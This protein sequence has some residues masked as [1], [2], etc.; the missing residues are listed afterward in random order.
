VVPATLTL[1][2]YNAP[3]KWAAMLVQ[4]TIVTSFAKMWKLVRITADCGDIM[5]AWSCPTYCVNVACLRIASRKS[6]YF[7]GLPQPLEVWDLINWSVSKT[8]YRNV[9]TTHW[10][11]VV[12]SPWHNRHWFF[13][14]GRMTH[15]NISYFNKLRDPRC[16]TRMQKTDFCGSQYLS[17]NVM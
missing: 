13:L 7:A 6:Q 9:S 14:M 5:L 2:R 15:E 1:T 12:P 11:Y 8:Q 16:C 17:H 10:L 4:E 3:V